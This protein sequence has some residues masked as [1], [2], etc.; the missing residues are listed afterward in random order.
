MWQHASSAYH[1]SFNGF[2][3]LFLSCKRTSRN[4]GVHDFETCFS[5]AT[6]PGVSHANPAMWSSIDPSSDVRGKLLVLS[7]SQTKQFPEP[8][9]LL[10]LH[11]GHVQVRPDGAAAMIT[12][13]ALRNA[14]SARSSRFALE[15]QT[16]RQRGH[17]QALW[18]SSYP[19]LL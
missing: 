10:I 6:W 9:G 14:I 11:R 8:V 3:A 2:A 16:W 19:A 7:L 17:M 5:W 1:V 18:L 15:F 4:A 12:V 13:S